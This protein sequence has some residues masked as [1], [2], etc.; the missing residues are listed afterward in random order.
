ME[1]P[2][3]ARASLREVLA[4]EG[5][6]RGRQRRHRLPTVPSGHPALDR[7]LPGGG[8]PR[9]ALTELLTHRPGLGETSLL[10][11]ALAPMIRGGGW[12]LLVDPPWAPC[13]AAFQGQGLELQRLV[14]IRTR[15][16]RESL[17]ACEQ[18]LRAACGGVVLAW[19]TEKKHQAGFSHLRRLQ[20]AAQGSRQC[21]FLFRPADAAGQASPSP[22]R[23]HLQA[24]GPQLD[25]TLLKCRGAHQGDTVRLGRPG[26]MPAAP[27][28]PPRARSGRVDAARPSSGAREARR[29][30][31]TLARP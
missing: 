16:A 5:V 14:L 30:E 28:K 7:R 10:L 6:W 4:H 27:A 15:D 9:G 25:L 3:A 18:A 19:L 1:R 13:P 11:P 17:W 26:M 20:L 24:E 8:W 22:L 21:A 12:L 2:A 31:R 23:L 29:H